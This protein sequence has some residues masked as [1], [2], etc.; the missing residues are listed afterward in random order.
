MKVIMYEKDPHLCLFALRT[1]AIDEELR[2]DYGVKDLWWRKSVTINAGSSLIQD[3]TVAGVGTN[4]QSADCVDHAGSSL[5]QD[6]TVAGVGTN[7]QS[8]DCVD[9]AGSS[10]IQDK[11]VAGVAA[12]ERSTQFT[13]YIHTGRRQLDVSFTDDDEDR[14]EITNDISIFPVCQCIIV[15]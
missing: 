9:H 8:A 2:Y 10:L 4:E 3:N 6:Q 5:I 7:E 1:I 13:D 14:D 11:T 12:G 15:H